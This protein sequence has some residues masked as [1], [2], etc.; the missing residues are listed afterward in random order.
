VAKATVGC[1]SLN[2]GLFARPR[3]RRERRVAP[4]AHRHDDIDGTQEFTSRDPCAF[5]ASSP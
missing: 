4:D 3:E 5:A 2:E 1:L